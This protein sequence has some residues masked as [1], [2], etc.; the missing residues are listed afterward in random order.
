MSDGQII[1]PDG[2]ERLPH[3]RY[4][5]FLMES[6]KND[7]FPYEKFSNFFNWTITYRSESDFSNPCGWV[8]PIYPLLDTTIDINHNPMD[9]IEG[10]ENTMP[11]LEN[12]KQKNSKKEKNVVWMVSNCDTDSQ[13]E[14]YVKE[15]QKH[16]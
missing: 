8:E 3:Q 9:T 5:M 4:V 1:L 10:D 11:F 15:L 12:L 16:I 6:P 7:W 2:K 14:D 13:R